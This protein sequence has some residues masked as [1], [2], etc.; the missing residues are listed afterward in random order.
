VELATG[1]KL[2]EIGISKS[3]IG[4][5]MSI[6]G[7]C[8]DKDGNLV[9]T[10]SIMH[11]VQVFDKNTGEYLYHIGGEKAIPY[12][13]SN[14]QRPFVEKMEGPV[15]PNIDYKGRIWIYVAGLK[16]AMIRELIGD[17]PWDANIDKPEGPSPK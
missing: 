12:L 15:R 17:K 10:D 14:S 9:V 13:R 7:M 1:K 11:T 6:T 2:Q 3:Y 4:A 16:G 5:F 8:L